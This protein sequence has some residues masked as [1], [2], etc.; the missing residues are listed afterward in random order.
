MLSERAQNAAGHVIALRRQCKA[1]QRDHG[2]AA[3]ITEPMVAGND[4]FLIAAR[5]DVLV[6]RCGQSFYKV[7]FHR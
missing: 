6:S 4:G 2:I 7:V 3:P 1:G 5:N